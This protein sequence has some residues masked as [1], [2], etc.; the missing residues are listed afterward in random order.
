MDG[1]KNPSS[2]EEKMQRIR[3]LV[4]DPWKREVI[5]SDKV[6]WDKVCS[7]MDVLEDAQLAINSYFELNDSDFSDEGKRYLYLYGLLQAFFLQQDAI[8]HL[9]QALFGKVIKWKRDYP[10][11][12]TIRELRNDAVGHPTSR[13]NDNSFHYIA[14]ASLSKQSFKLA[15]YY[16]KRSESFYY[17]TINL[18]DLKQK[19]ENDLCNILEKVIALLEGEIQKHK[20]RFKNMKIVSLIPNDLNYIIE[21][22]Y[23]GIYSNYPLAKMNFERLKKSYERIK[24]EIIKRYQTLDALSGVKYNT[25]DIDYILSRFE[26]WIKENKLYKNKDAE[27][28]LYAFEHKFSEFKEI[29]EEIDDEFQK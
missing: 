6:K 18:Y 29:L 14:R 15:S 25:E 16:P 10:D 11:L 12:Y 7:S 9:Y 3:E 19:Q 21:K 17:R 28:F 24:D 27:I 1:I 22:L 20:G 2:I 23:E 26:A 8:N 5:F 13:N 4:N